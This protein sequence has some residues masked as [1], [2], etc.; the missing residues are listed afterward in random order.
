MAPVSRK[1]RVTMPSIQIAVFC[2]ATM[3]NLIL[4]RRMLVA[5]GCHGFYRFFVF[6]SIIALITLNFPYWYED[7]FS[8]QQIASWIALFAS[9]FYVVAGLYLLHTVGKPRLEQVKS[10]EF[11]F[12]N[13]TKLVRVGLYRFI[14]HPMYGSLLFLA[15]GTFLKRVNAAT[16]VLVC[17]SLISIWLT[18]RAE[19]RENLERFGAADYEQYKSETKMFIPYLW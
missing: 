8:P 13:T 17:I 7:R 18:A 5:P 10:T 14:R 12:E 4:S 2:A 19:E 11:R 9:L 15:V 3:G 1:G 6:E 16:I